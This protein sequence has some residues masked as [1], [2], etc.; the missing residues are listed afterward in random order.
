MDE[1]EKT[2]IMVSVICLAYNH[3]EYIRDAL[4]GFVSQVTDFEYEVIVHDDASDDGTTL[5]IEEFQKKYPQIIKPIYQKENQYSK[6]VDLIKEFLA[7]SAKG[8]Y[9]AL[10]EGDD[11]WCNNYKLQKQV[12][13]LE[14]TIDTEVA[15]ISN[16]RIKRK[17]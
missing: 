4:E 7:P 17:L 3:I 13:F 9:I 2:N 14:G 16:I 11:Y 8:K 6:K 15:T 12:E 5:I 1:K 10:C